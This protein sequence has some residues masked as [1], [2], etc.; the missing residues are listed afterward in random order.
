MLTEL[1]DFHLPEGLIALRPAD[2]RD[3][4]RLLVVQENGEIRHHRF[5]E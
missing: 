2:P 4:A 5:H 1:F 3:S